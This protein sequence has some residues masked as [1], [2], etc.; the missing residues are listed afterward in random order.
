[1]PEDRLPPQADRVLVSVNPMAG[2]RSADDRVGRLVARLGQ[3][4]FQA[5]IHGNL[6]E[7]AQ[8]AAEL[9]GLGQLRAVVA[10]G[11][12]GTVAELV[13]R[14]P[15][16]APLAIL[17]A[18]TE[19]LL[20][21]YF[22]FSP[23]PERLAEALGRG[24]L[25]RRDAGQAAGRVFLL[26]VSAGFDAAVVHRFHGRRS[27]HIHRLDYLGSILHTAV[28]YRFPEIRIYWTS[29]KAAEPS[30][31]GELTARWV[32]AFNLPCYGGGFRVC[33][34]ADGTDGLLD[35]CAFRRGG[36]LHGLHLAALVG[37]DSHQRLDE[38]TTLRTRRLTITAAEPVPYQ[39]DGDPAGMLP[40]DVE[41]VPGRLTLLDPGE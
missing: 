36:F 9:Y 14:T 13:N 1:M 18:G 30:A 29:E 8:R 6:A 15:P 3:A 35:L 7:V 33:P 17:P 24:R 25:L 32:F 2:A 27:G 22:G 28:H 26:M 12:D 5:E 39:L 31:G 34:Q 41:S 23:Q 16:G 21:R 38:W 11:G 40:L 4:G 20:A 37:M 19:N 10:V